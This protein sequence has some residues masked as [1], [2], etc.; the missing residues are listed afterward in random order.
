[1][2]TTTSLERMQ[3]VKTHMGGFGSRIGH[4]ESGNPGHSDRWLASSD[5][6]GRSGQL[7]KL[8]ASASKGSVD[9]EPV[10][11]NEELPGNRSAPLSAAFGG[12]GPFG[13]AYAL[14]VVDAL[15][16]KGVSFDDVDMIGTS[17]GSWVAS[18]LAADTPFERLCEL[19]EVGVPNLKP[20]FLQGIATEVFGDAMD[21][22][23]T[24]CAMR[25]PAMKRELLNGS[26]YRLADIV[27]AS[28]AVP[29]LFRPVHIGPSSY[30]D[31]GVRSLVSA[32]RAAPAHHLLV[33]A[34]IAGPMFGPGGRTMELML[35]RELGA[36]QRRT[37]GRAHVVRPNREIASL[38]RQPLHLFDNKRAKRA[39]ALAYGQTNEL[40]LSRPGFAE[41][42]P[43][44]VV[45]A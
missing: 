29:G 30:V 14:G 16:A 26:A 39:Y 38:A 11:L 24:G 41:L 1:V 18:C 10:T 7:T 13:I 31:G 8:G 23:V 28:S 19:P 33:I 32:D 25:L 3:S 44:R 6:S 36:W 43:E 22:R 42:L 40:L 37:G 9:I 4:P 34:P 5:I 2:N 15:K 21:A 12:G 45:A 20:G 35:R 27:A 17:A